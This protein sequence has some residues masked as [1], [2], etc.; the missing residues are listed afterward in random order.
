MTMVMDIY[1][2][3]DNTA[4][5]EAAARQEVEAGPSVHNNQTMRSENGRKLATTTPGTV[6][7]PPST[8]T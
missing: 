2:D 6:T 7:M 4:S 8:T 3:D 1:D 5:C